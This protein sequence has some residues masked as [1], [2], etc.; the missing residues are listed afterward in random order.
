MRSYAEGNKPQG[1]PGESPGGPQ[2][3]DYKEGEEEKMGVKN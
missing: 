3:V 1:Y 2:E